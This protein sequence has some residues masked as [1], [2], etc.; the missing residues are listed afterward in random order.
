MISIEDIEADAK[1]LEIRDGAKAEKKKKKKAKSSAAASSAVGTGAD[2][3]EDDPNSVQFTDGTLCCV[4]KDWKELPRKVAERYASEAT[5]VDLCYNELTT[6][7]HIG[8]FT[9]CVE[10]VLDNNSLG[11]GVTFPPLPNLTTLTLNKNKISDTE[12]FLSQVKDSYPKLSFLSL[13]G[14]TACPN[15]LV[16]K[17]EDDYQ[18]YRYYV[19]HTLPGLKFLDS[20]GVSD[21]ERTEAARVGKFMKVVTVTAEDME[22][23]FARQADSGAKNSASQFSP[24]PQESRNAENHRGTIGTCKYVYFGRHSE[25]NRFIRNSDL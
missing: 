24:L 22:A 17:D 20:R 21:K 18:R 9:Q 16:L 13:L 23:E 10:L 11:D 5:R 1:S 19:L 15:E 12:A 3:G 7:K 6:L 2:D 8:K 25:G 14:N 4:G